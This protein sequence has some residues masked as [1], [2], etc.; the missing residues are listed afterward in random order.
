VVDYKL[1]VSPAFDD[2]P[3]AFEAVADLL[4]FSPGVLGF[5]VGRSL[6]DLC[7]PDKLVVYFTRQE[8]LQQGASA[9]R[10]RLAGYAAHGVP[11]TAAVTL[12]G[13]LSWGVDPPRSLAGLTAEGSWRQWVTGRLADYIFAAV[14]ADML[15]VEPWQFALE[16]LQLDG[17]DTE[18]WIPSSRLWDD[19]LS[20]G[21]QWWS[22]M[23]LSCHQM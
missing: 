14:G 9:L 4:A 8:D 17:V 21:K 11:F 10:D 15:P 12:D 18:T 22:T 5:K 19:M 16:R 1:Y 6:A 3:A 7:R 2:L 23:P 13:M 20:G